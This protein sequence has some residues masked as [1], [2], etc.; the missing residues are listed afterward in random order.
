MLF[1]F[2]QFFPLIPVRILEH[3]DL[4]QA[5]VA[6]R[7]ALLDERMDARR[8]FGS[9]CFLASVDVLKCFELRGPREITVPFKGNNMEYPLVI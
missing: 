5:R 9:Y 2:I 7:N 1:I 8:C 4:R 6:V 3:S